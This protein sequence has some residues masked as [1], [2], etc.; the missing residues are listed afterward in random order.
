MIGAMRVK[1]S[2]VAV[3]GVLAVGAALAGCGSTSSNPPLVPC[4]PPAGVQVALIYPAPGSTA[5]PDAFTQVVIASS[6]ALPATFDVA[7]S[8]A[9]G[10]VL[11]GTVL[12]AATPLPSP[13]A[14]PPFANPVYYT[15]NNTGFTFAA[16]T[17]L[18]A[19]IN[20]TNSACTP[21]T[22]LG[23]FTTQ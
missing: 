16:G 8:Y 3:F 21:G 18:T 9:T 2:F 20:D 12:P 5:I 17:Q 7:L 23:S 19:Q 4:T 6:G 13:A 15:S 1:A 22:S 14:T 11:F 10:G